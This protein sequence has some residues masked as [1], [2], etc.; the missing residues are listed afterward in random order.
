V[1]SGAQQIVTSLPASGT[2]AD[3][4]ARCN[5]GDRARAACIRRERVLPNLSLHP[6]LPIRCPESAPHCH[7]LE[8]GNDSYRLKHSSTQP[9][10]TTAKESKTKK[11]ST[12]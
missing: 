2:R 8:T 6:R 3:E 12:P 9:R 4:G 5:A 10:T 1:C 7:I 11:S